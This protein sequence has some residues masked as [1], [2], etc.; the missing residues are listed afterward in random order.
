MEELPLSV[1]IDIDHLAKTLTRQIDK[2]A[3]RRKYASIEDVLKLVGAGAFLAA[4]VAFPN[5]PLVLKS[6]IS[7]SSD[8]NAWKR[9]NIRYLKRSLERLEKKKL[10][11]VNEDEGQQ[12]VKITDKG[13]KRI[14][15][16][17][18]DQLEVQKPKVWDGTWRLVSYDLPQLNSTVRNIFR[19]Y[20]KAWGFYPLHESVY[21][22]AYPCA[23]EIEFLR[24]YLMIGEYVRIF[25]VSQIE[26]DELFREFFGI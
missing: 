7:D 23:K 9:F 1:K 3:F 18:L 16:C 5:L 25:K 21:L 10:V 4:S 8:Y 2:D 13:R 11:E 22:H 24:E 26:N 15:R 6:F 19:S 12:I 17:A 14:L 20:L